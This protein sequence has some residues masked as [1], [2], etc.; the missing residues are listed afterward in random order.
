[1]V[2]ISLLIIIGILL[3]LAEILIVPGIGVAGLLGIISMGG[4]CYFAFAEYGTLAGYIVTFINVVL[5]VVLTVFALR[6]KT[7]K[8]LALNTKIDSKVNVF[9]E[10][11]LA[12]GDR[13]KTLTRLAPT[14]MA[15]IGN[16]KYEVTS[17][18][19]IIDSRTEIEV[20]LMEDN[21]I[22]VKPLGEDF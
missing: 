10:S 22:Y 5:A 19:G 6:S 2:F 12:V 1:M 8:K 11:R 9:D 16:T 18:E 21:K 7:W 14:G 15:S 17:L 4:S 13:G 20:V 3:L